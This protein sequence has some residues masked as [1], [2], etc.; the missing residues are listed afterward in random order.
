MPTAI[1]SRI[2]GNNGTQQARDPLLRRA[3]NV[4]RPRLD[5]AR[6]ILG[7]FTAGLPRECHA[8]ARKTA[9]LAR[10]SLGVAR[11]AAATAAG[12]ESEAGPLRGVYFEPN[13]ESKLSP[14]VAKK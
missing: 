10:G 11:P 3:Q 4:R 2:I 1:P 9:L 7:D 6:S 8:A 5:P 13:S 12:R 14:R